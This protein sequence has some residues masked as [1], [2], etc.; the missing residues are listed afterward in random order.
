M[1]QTANS[2]K[3]V[4]MSSFFSAFVSPEPPE[5]MNHIHFGSIKT[6]WFCSYRNRMKLK[7]FIWIMFGVWI[8]P[9]FAKFRMTLSN[10][11][12]NRWIWFYLFIHMVCVFTQSNFLPISNNYHRNVFAVHTSSQYAIESDNSFSIYTYEQLAE[13]WRSKRD[14]KV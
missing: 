13:D 8:Q 11:S 2:P 10:I 1:K 6:K 5:A 4:L 14:E 9:T 12:N 3:I 7:L